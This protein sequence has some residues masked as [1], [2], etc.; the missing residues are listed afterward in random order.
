MKT[1][2]ILGNGFDLDL[3]LNTSY[4]DFVRSDI[5]KNELENKENRLAIKIKEDY[6]HKGW[7]DV[8]LSI[9][10]Y[11]LGNE[12]K[13]REIK[14][15]KEEFDDICN[16][17]GEFMSSE[18][19]RMNSSP[20]FKGVAGK[21][22][23]VL[24]NHEDLKIQSFNYTR[25]PIIEKRLKLENWNFVHGCVF[26][27]YLDTVEIPI[28]GCDADER[29]P[30]EY[31]FIIKTHRHHYK[32]STIKK[33]LSDAELVIVFGH[34]FGETD[35]NYFVDFISNCHAKKVIV[36]T[37]DC[38][39]EQKILQRFIVMGGC[40]IV[41]KLKCNNLLEIFYTSCENNDEVERFLEKI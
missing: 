30:L 2:L 37:R 26:P 40:G 32:P 8:E 13:N 29:I 4:A 20:I 27:Y 9:K 39:S 6:E 38:D 18:C 28:V 5:F 7:V 31:S 35:N 21:L 23:R 12:I 16:S 14:E 34:S 36:F 1:L 11:V 25:F 24:S 33:D 22:L 41:E 10:N 15:V 17:I 19:G 3:G